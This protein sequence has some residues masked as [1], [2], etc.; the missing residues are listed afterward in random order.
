MKTKETR[1]TNLFSTG[2]RCFPAQFPVG[3]APIAVISLIIGRSH[4]KIM[5]LH[6][7]HAS[8]GWQSKCRIGMA[9]RTTTHPTEHAPFVY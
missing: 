6:Y 4:D 7:N 2:G 9:E 1:C 5:V 8:A 3:G